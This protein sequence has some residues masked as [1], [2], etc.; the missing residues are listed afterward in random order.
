MMHAQGVRVP[1]VL[2]GHMHSQLKGGRARV[3]LPVVAF[4]PQLACLLPLLAAPCCAVGCA[5]KPCLPRAAL[6]VQPC[7]MLRS[8]FFQACLPEQAASL[9]WPLTATRPMRRPGPPQH[10]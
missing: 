4:P 3:C 5:C 9:P 8:C 2:F 10:G 1:L 6:P 7:G